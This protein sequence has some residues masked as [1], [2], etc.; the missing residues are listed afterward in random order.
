[1]SACIEVIS[2]STGGTETDVR[3]TPLLSD[4]DCSIAKEDLV[5]NFRC[6]KVAG[7][8][9]FCLREHWGLGRTP[10]EYR[11]DR[12]AAARA[13]S[14]N[15]GRLFLSFAYFFRCVRLMLLMGVYPFSIDGLRAER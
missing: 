3:S 9:F 12:Q 2:K 13:G 6:T 1:L 15:C 7:R 5:R 10:W 14:L 8:E 4:R 11:F